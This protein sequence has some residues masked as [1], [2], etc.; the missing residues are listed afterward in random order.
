MASFCVVGP[1]GVSFAI[2]ESVAQKGNVVSVQLDKYSRYH[3]SISDPY[4]SHYY[5]GGICAFSL[6]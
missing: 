3:C 4:F 1:P 6:K 5:L 2:Y